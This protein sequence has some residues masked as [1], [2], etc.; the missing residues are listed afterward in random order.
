[1]GLYCE[2]YTVPAELLEQLPASPDL[3]V[4]VEGPH[5]SL[6][7]AWHGLHFLL[8]GTAFEG[9]APLNFLLEGGEALG[10]DEDDGGPRVFPPEAVRL[11][12]AALAQISEDTLWARFDPERMEA[13]GVYPQIWDEG[14]MDLKDEYL[15]YFRELKTFFHN[16]SAAG[17]AVVIDIG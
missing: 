12:D 4:E 15:F 8:T 11:I 10:D 3:L 9:D 1:M 16:A 5:L 13:D 17:T 14:E 7:K 2:L 6:E